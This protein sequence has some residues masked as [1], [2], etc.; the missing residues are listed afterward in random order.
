MKP[1]VTIITASY[2]YAKYITY[3]I[4]SVLNQSYD[5]WEYLII[6]DGSTDNSIEII[7]NYCKKNQKIKLLTHTN[8][9]NKGLIETLKLGIAKA[10]GEYIVFLESD[11][12]ITP[13]YLEKKLKLFSNDNS[14]K[15]IYN[16]ITLINENN[17]QLNPNLYLTQI[18]KYWNKHNY[19]HSIKN[20]ISLNNYIPTFS[21]VMIR[22]TIIKNCNFDSPKPAWVD[23]WL[24][25]QIA[26]EKI[27]CIPEK[28][29]YYRIHQDSYI[30]K[31]LS[32]KDYSSIYNFYKE[33]YKIISIPDGIFNIIK[34]KIK[35][36]LRLI[37]Y[38]FLTKNI[39][40]RRK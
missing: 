22:T 17:Q 26:S 27:Y 38:K 35:Q 40:Y 2:N 19:A 23:W 3:T 12:F 11:D 5:N 10:K 34:F 32:I 25:S 33:F 14:I 6:D 21:S 8:N 29:T 20:I 7:N 39:A 28:L 15:F 36:I 31:D 18:E 13:D 30:N 37:K 24:W 1:L 4:E 16:Y 9:E